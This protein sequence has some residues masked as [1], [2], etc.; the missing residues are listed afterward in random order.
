MSHSMLCP[1]S[2]KQQLGMVGVSYILVDRTNEWTEV[3]EGLLHT[4]PQTYQA[5]PDLRIF[6]AFL[7]TELASAISRVDHFSRVPMGPSCGGTRDTEA[8]ATP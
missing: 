5:P 6:R 2:L 4:A 7:P 1:Q 8:L 3:G